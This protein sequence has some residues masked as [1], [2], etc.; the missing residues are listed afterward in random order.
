MA[1]TMSRDTLHHLVDALP[2]GA[3]DDAA[4]YLEALGTA[5][6]VL[7]ALLLAPEDDESETDEERAAT[8][9]AE[10]DATAGRVVS[11]AEARRRLL[12]DA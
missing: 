4:R 5:D 2:D 1:R 3:L 8:V 7:R 11:Q 10:A 9:E 12:G 6:P